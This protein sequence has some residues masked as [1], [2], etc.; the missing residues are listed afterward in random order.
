MGILVPA[1]DRLN[2]DAVTAKRAVESSNGANGIP[3]IGGK[4]GGSGQPV[5]QFTGD[6]VKA[7]YN[8]HM[9]RPLTATAPARPR[10]ARWPSQR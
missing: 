3:W 4:A 8:I 6:L 9:N 10:R 1:H 2:N 5:L 7:G